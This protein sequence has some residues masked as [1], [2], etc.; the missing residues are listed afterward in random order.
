MISPAY[1]DVHSHL[2]SGLDDGCVS[3]APSYDFDL[4]SN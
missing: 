1:I 2:L 3:T 4:K